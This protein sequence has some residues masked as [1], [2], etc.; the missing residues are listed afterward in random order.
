MVEF[1]RRESVDVDL[2][3]FLAEV[4]E[5][6]EVEI[7]AK[8]RMMPA[9][10]QDLGAADFQE[11]INF[12]VDLRVGQNVVVRVLFGPVKIAKLAIDV[13]NVGVVD[14]AVENVG[15]N[16]IAVS[17][18][19]IFLNL[20]TPGVGEL[21]KIG[22]GGVI[23]FAKLF[24]ADPFSGKDFFADLSGGNWSDHDGRIARVL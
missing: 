7:N 21:A 2:G 16:L 4:I 18:V 17:S 15:H 20:L 23:K 11:F 5:E 19:G 6:I 9:L 3:I 1:R 14:V 22:Q 12:L 13:A 10:H 24:A 8:F